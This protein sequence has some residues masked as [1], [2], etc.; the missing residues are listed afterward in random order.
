MGLPLANNIFL[1]FRFDIY[2]LLKLVIINLIGVFHFKMIPY[3]DITQ[4]V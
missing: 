4:N 3:I 2:I 1:L